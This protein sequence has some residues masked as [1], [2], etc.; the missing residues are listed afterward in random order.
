MNGLRSW[1]SGNVVLI[2]PGDKIYGEDV[3]YTIELEA[4][5]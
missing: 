4:H 2:K 1:G 5:Q 3:I